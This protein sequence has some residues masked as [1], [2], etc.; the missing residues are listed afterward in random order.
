MK[1]FVATVLVLVVAMA[2]VGCF[3]GCQAADESTQSADGNWK[4][5]E[6]ED[7]S[8]SLSAYTGTAANV[9]VPA[10]VDGKAVSSIEAGLFVKINDGSVKRR[11][12]DVYE[13]NELIESVTFLANITAIPER[14]FYLCKNLTAVVF[15]AALESIGDFAFYG[16]RSLTSIA[17]PAT[18]SSIGAYCFRECENLTNVA[19]ANPELVKIGDKC[20]YMVNTKASGDDQ[21]YIIKDLKIVPINPTV[22][23]S[24]AIEADRRATKKN[25][26]RYWKDYID[27][28]NV[29]G[30][31]PS[32]ETAE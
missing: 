23:D 13:D 9:V 16:C 10:I 6:K 3:V 30:G 4:Y 20:F 2:M 27:N 11:M 28:G 5:V 8:V 12:R 31:I 25:D 32:A 19:I 17:L 18:C 22:Y 1:K 29:V 24:D 14:T 26:Y 15:P 7:G 21:Y